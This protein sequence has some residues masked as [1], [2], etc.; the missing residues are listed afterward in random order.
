[1]RALDVVV[2]ASV[3]PE[4]FGRVIIEAMALERAVIASAAGGA[5]EIVEHGISGL[6][7][8]P[9]DAQSLAD[10]IDVLLADTELR[11]R[12]GK[13]GRSRVAERFSR[14]AMTRSVLDAYDHVTGTQPSTRSA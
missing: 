3:N 5:S 13:A 2:H 4:P 14:D 7:H 10:A 6:V 12:L 8:R 9:G 1:M 11:V